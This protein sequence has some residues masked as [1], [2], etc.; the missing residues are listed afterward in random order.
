MTKQTY[1]D[2]KYVMTD[3]GSLYLGAKYSYR[4][5]L[6]NQDVPFKYRSIIERYILPDLQP[7]TTLESHLYYM[8]KNAFSYRTYQ[9]LK[10]KVKVSR[11][12][13]KNPFLGCIGKKKR[14]YQTVVLSLEELAGMSKE[15]KERDGIFIQEL[16][17][18]KL[19][20]MTFIL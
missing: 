3:T 9:Q 11:L 15:E 14:V 8:Q 2:Y 19:C 16:I 20:M 18:S 10:A 17:I 13:D 6:E 7:D 12:V 4:E 5:I 1:E